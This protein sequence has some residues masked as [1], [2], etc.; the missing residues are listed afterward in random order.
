MA[1]PA[2]PLPQSSERLAAERPQRVLLGI[3]LAL[4]AIGLFVVMDTI[5]KQLMTR[6][7]MQ[8][9]AWARYFFQFALMLLL[10]LVP[11]YGLRRLVRTGQPWLQ[12]LRGLLLAG[13][14]I[15][16]LTAIS[17]IPLAEAYTIG[18]T[19]PLLVTLFAIPLLGE[20][21][22]W[23]RLAAVLTGFVGV[24]I[25]I[26]P[27]MAEVH[28]AMLMPLVMAVCFALYQV[29][30]RKLGS[31]PGESSVAMLFHVAW[32]GSLIVSLI[33]PFYWQPVA[34]ADWPWLVAM[35]A[36]GTLGHLLLIRALAMAPA[37]VLTG[38]IYTQLLWA[39]LF[40]YLFFGD[41]PDRWTL[42]G[43]S[44][45]IASGLFTFY[46]ESA[47]RRGAA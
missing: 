5:G 28:W 6:Y 2:D 20:P 22:G 11:R 42:L 36:L 1:E 43:G 8:Q 15:A 19:S 38:F 13:S 10:I 40:G 34:L 31:Q 26:R 7:P 45:I 46:R 3:G 14:T 4:A 29:L 41:L 33:A 21:V 16:M 12:I 47:R 30:T 32:V 35:G 23:R 25:V 37:S 9:V 39:I 18:F 17:R 24:L 27:G 44:V